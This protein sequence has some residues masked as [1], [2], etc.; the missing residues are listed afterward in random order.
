MIATFQIE[1]LEN[2]IAPG[3]GSTAYKAGYAVG[4]FLS[5]AATLWGL[6]G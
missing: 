6:F 2:V 4:K 5:G 3:K 1:S